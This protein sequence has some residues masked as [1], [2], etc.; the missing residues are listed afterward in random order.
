MLIRCML[1]PPQVPSV[2]SEVLQGCAL[3]QTLSLHSNPITPEVLQ[4]TE[5]YEAYEA[6]RRSK[7]DKAITGGVL[8]NSSGL[9]EGLD[10]QT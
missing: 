10:R 3:L 2:P 1:T 5:G 8:L 6:R 7:L 9:D 4:E